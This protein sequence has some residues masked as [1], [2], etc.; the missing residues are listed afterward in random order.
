MST[1]NHGV[2]LHQALWAPLLMGGVPRAW[3]IVG[4]TLTAVIVLGL[5]QILIG[6]P[7]GLAI[8]GLGYA[9]T[10]RDPQWLEALKRHIQHRPFWAG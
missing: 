5:G 2:P 7:L 3:Y 4:G 9:L 10:K 8:H 1:E 6:I